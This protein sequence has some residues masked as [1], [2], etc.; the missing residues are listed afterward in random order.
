MFVKGRRRHLLT[1]TLAATSVLAVG[2]IAR[3]ADATTAASA[4]NATSLGEL[5]VTAEKR[6]ENIQNVAASIQAITTAKI[7]QL[8]I[9]NFNDYIKYLPSVSYQ[10]LG[11]GYANVYMRGIAA[12]NYSNHSGSQPVVG[13]YLDE[14]PITTIGGPLDI[15]T[16]DIARVE[17]LAGPQGTLYGASSLAGTIRIITNKP[18]LNAFHAAYDAEVNTVDHGGTGYLGEGFINV[19]LGDRAA[20]RLVAWYEHDAGYIDNVHGTR[21]F[22]TGIHVDNAALVKNDFNTAR[23]YGGRLTL[24]YDVNDNWTITP[25]VMAQDQ[26]SNGVFGYDPKLGDLKVQHFRPEYSHDHWLQ[27]A[28]TIQGKI[29][30]FDV[31]YSGGHMDRRITSQL[32]YTDYSYFYDQYAGYAASFYDANHNYIDPTQTII[33]HDHFTKDSHELRIA[34]PQGDRFRVLAGLFYERQTHFILQDYYINPQFTTPYSV[35]GWP[36]TLW[37]TDEYRT[38][39]DYAAFGEA[40][41]DLTDKLSVTGGVRVYHSD[42]SLYG[43]YGFNANFSSKT[44]EAKCFAPSS[45]GNGPC[46]NLN[47][48]VKYTGETHR[49]NLTYKFDPDRMVY[50]TY[51][52]GF[53]PGGVNRNGNLPPYRPDTLTNFELGW[54]TT[55]MGGALRWNGD[56][57]YEL[58]RNLQFSYLGPNSLTVVGNAGDATVYGLE[59]D[60]AWRVTPDFTLTGALAYTHATLDK[61]FC[62]GAEDPCLPADITARA[63]QQLPVTPRFKANAT[64]RYE[65]DVA[66]MRAHVQG[67]LVYQDSSWSD[68]LLNDRSILGLQKSYTTVDFNLGVQ[69]ANWTLDLSILNAFDERAQLYRYTECTIAICGGGA[70]LTD[71]G[72]VYTVPNRPRTIAL[73]FGQ[74]F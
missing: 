54:K 70:N 1:T 44:G 48:E 65:F 68:L 39:R 24:R 50:F 61:D 64:A 51:S 29:S 36:G 56:V 47:K 46:T 58:W 34:S 67:A 3:A 9:Q 55:W 26:R 45:V 2:G 42:N 35:T 60:A 72:T 73:R 17:S 20:V 18:E 66:S 4:D 37:L 31:T 62:N 63:G 38:D 8:H 25:M 5:I 74:K 33:G 49:V 53:R 19:P 23:T 16:Y 15:H 10:S 6:E 12:D 13:T 69:H 22:S 40:T 43:F 27:A 30:N 11:P 71:Q 41:Y 59:T 21:D 7:E 32:D 52:T 14:Q 28:L 57:Y